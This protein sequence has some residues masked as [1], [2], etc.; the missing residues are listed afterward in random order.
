MTRV[1]VFS[2]RRRALLGII[3]VGAFAASTVGLVACA[4]TLTPDQ[5]KLLGKRSYRGRSRAE[6][7]QASAIALKTLGYE[8]VVQDT[9]TGQVKTAPKALVAMASGTATTAVAVT[10]DMAWLLEVTTAGDGVDVQATPRA[11]SAGQAYDGPL[12]AD[13][14]EKAFAELFQEIESN[15]KPAKS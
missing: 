4:R 10:N 3:G 13:Y 12:N 15:L 5:V 6:L 2:M 11:R 7:V 9:D 8:V 1:I 14:M